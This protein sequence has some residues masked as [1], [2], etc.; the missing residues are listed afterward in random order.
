[1]LNT[2]ATQRK[3]SA[4]KDLSLK[5]ALELALYRKMNPLFLSYRDKF[6]ASIEEINLIPSV[7]ELQNQ[8]NKILL[9]HYTNVSDVFS[10]RIAKELGIPENHDDILSSIQNKTDTHNINRAQQQ[11]QIISETTHK[12]SVDSVLEANKKAEERGMILTG[13]ALAGAAA[14]N[15]YKKI[16]GRT[17]V[18][19][20]TETQNPAEHAKQKEIEVLTHHK[21]KD[22]HERKQEKQWH[23]I[24][25][26]VTRDSHALADLQIVDADE[27]YIV[28]S[29]KLMYPGDTSL[30]ASLEN[31]INCRCSSV[32]IIR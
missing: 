21:Y 23:A 7:D 18:I 16:K 9:E 27:P 2:N 3:K 15:L 6:K 20:A 5:L 11:S 12:D 29:E 32:P 13:A 19:A 1:M 8:L 17:S 24:L 30:G 31:V 22:I 14:L 26:S 4:A 10:K 28:M 25:D